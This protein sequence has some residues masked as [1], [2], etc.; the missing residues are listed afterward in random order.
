MPNISV[1][2]PVYKAEKTLACFIEN[3]FTV[4]GA[5]ELRGKRILV[6]EKLS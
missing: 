4:T 1:I 5:K 3:G 2:I 6:L